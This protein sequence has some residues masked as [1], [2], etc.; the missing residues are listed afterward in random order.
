[1]E[2][3]TVKPIDYETLWGTPPELVSNPSDS[4]CPYSESICP[5]WNP[6]AGC[7][8][9]QCVHSQTGMEALECIAV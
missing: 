7:E 2:E 8:S 3:Q 9:G 5:Y 4:L 6:K 1:M